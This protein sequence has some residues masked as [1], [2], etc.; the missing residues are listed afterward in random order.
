MLDLEPI[1]NRLDAATPGP[2][3]VHPTYP[4][5]LVSAAE[6]TMSLLALDVDNYAI[7]EDEHDASLIAHAPGDL[8]ALVAEVKRLRAIIKAATP[9]VMC[10]NGDGLRRG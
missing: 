2:W 1:E 7:V 3:L 4:R 9:C 8:A 10:D 5:C 6:P